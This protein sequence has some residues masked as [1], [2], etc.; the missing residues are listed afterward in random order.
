MSIV[1]SHTER[2]AWNRPNGH[3]EAVS[4]GMISKA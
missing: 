2:P 1:F 3:G 4:T